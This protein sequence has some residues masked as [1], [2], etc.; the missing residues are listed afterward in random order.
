MAGLNRFSSA[1]L[2]MGRS[3]STALV[4]GNSVTASRSCSLTAALES[5]TEIITIAKQLTATLDAIPDVEQLQVSGRHDPHPPGTCL[6]SLL[7]GACCTQT[8]H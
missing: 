5:M 2:S 1:S 4:T 7:P 3:L 6:Q 8:L